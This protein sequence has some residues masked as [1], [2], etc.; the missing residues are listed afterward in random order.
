MKMELDTSQRCAEKGK[1]QWLQVAT[2]EIQKRFKEKLFYPEMVQSPSSEISRTSLEGA[3][4]SL[5]EGGRWPVFEQR[6]GLETS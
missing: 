6:V 3:L 1:R 4:S 2:R 5:T